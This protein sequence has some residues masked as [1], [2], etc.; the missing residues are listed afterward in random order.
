MIVK[1]IILEISDEDTEDLEDV[2]VK[3]SRVLDLLE[4]LSANVLEIKKALVSDT[5]PTAPLE[6]SV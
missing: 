1:K 3:C 6:D 4:D 5:F 2:L